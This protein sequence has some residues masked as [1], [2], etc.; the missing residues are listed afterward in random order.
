[1]KLTRTQWILLTVLVAGILGLT[2][3]SR[4]GK[5]VEVVVVTQGPMVQ[6]VVTTGRIASVARNDIASQST[7]RIEAILVREGDTVRAGQVLVRLRDDEASANL[8]QARATVTEARGKIRQLA[9][10]QEPVSN[11][12]LEQARATDTQAVRELERARDL[13]KQ[14]FVSQSR[15]DEAQRAAD[16]SAAA[17][18][19]AAT[20]AAGNSS[21]GAEAALAQ[22]RLE[23]ALAA[24][25]A[26][27][28]RLDQLSL[29][30]PAAGT[31][32]SRAADP[33]DTAQIGRAILT[34]VSGD[35]TR[36]EA[37]VDEKNLGY[38]KLN[39]TARATA[40]AYPKRPFDAVLTF[41]APAVDAQRG[42]V[43]LKLRVDKAVDYLRPDM[44][45][46]VEIITAQEPNAIKLPTDAVRRDTNGAVYALVNR[47]GRAEKVSLTL[48]LRGI[49]SS[50]VVK[51]LVAGDRVI[52]PTTSADEGDRVREQSQR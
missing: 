49:G 5:A 20:Q 40:D 32:I 37:S 15:V 36:I 27:A 24:E 43:D 8:A 6:S 13:L 14:G 23:Q 18:R 30:S 42:T 52:T 46:S 11:Q 50:Q 47:D 21:S 22:S 25:K 12:Q 4:R 1:M 41:I 33:G 35:E 34:L 2:I 10:V 51:G 31:V 48:G 38:L 44:T 26:A 29:R 45:V 28:T 3:F 19:A 17:V 9:T 7:A 16:T 39:Q